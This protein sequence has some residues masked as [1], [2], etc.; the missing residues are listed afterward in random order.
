MTG[1][2]I[3]RLRGRWRSHGQVESA[4]RE[5]QAIKLQEIGTYLRQAREQ[6]AL[7]LE[8]IELRTKIQPRLLRAIEAGDLSQLPEP[9]FIQGYIKLFA[10]ALG[11]DGSAL[12][13]AFPTETLMRLPRGKQSRSWTKAQLQPI[14]L[15]CLY[16]GLIFIAVNGLSYFIG[17][18][19]LPE[20]IEVTSEQLQPSLPTNRTGS[21]STAVSLAVPAT[22]ESK[23][24]SAV[25]GLQSLEHAIFPNLVPVE[26]SADLS[27]PIQVA[28]KLKEQSWLRVEV[29][30]NTLLEGVLSEGTERAWGANQR[31]V[32]RA[33][34]A[35]GV[36][37]AVN[38]EQAKPMGE[39]GAVE[40]MTIAAKPSSVS[41]SNAS[42]TMLD[43]TE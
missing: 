42:A 39:P 9:V 28:I 6:R 22:S 5:E 18:P 36:L 31:V 20:I 13:A 24:S 37:V 29:D 30:G 27:K 17:D 14:H 4:L 15:Y 8:D 11:M 25:T 35:G 7:S 43:R 23:Q 26:D 40:E 33:G 38:R 16:A 10:Q 32:I 12:S 41:A 2:V 1:N 21:T 19:S 34:N 3:K